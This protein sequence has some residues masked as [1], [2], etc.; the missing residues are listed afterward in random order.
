MANIMNNKLYNSTGTCKRKVSK[1]DGQTLDCYCVCCELLSASKADA[2]LFIN[3][4]VSGKFHGHFT[5]RLAVN[6]PS[7]QKQCNNNL[8]FQGNL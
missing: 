2:L 1:V 7:L 6:K 8:M 4:L 5:Q 3:I